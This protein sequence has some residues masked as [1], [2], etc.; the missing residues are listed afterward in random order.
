M[1][2]LS[3]CENFA[4][5]ARTAITFAAGNKI[6]GGDVGVSPGTSITGAYEI[7][8]G[9]LATVDDSKL[10][11]T[12]AYNAWDAAMV[13]RDDAKAL[14]VEMG[15]NIFEPGTWHSDNIT[16][17]AGIVFL[18][19]LYQ[20]NPVFL[21]QADISMAV[22]AGVKI[23]LINGAKAENVVW[24]LRTS[25][26]FGAN[27]DFKGSILAGT[28]IVFGADVKVHGCVVAGTA[29]TF[30]AGDSVT[31]FPVSG[32]P[33]FGAPSSPPSVSPSLI[34]TLS[35]TSFPSA[36]PT[37]SPTEIPT[38]S[39]TSSPTANPSNSPTIAPTQSSEIPTLSPTA[40]PSVTPS[41]SPTITTE[42]PTSSPSVTSLLLLIP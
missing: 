18:D 5:H 12:S 26:V 7:V 3:V 30:G 24:A 13:I 11:A 6:V 17:A 32:S 16:I 21:F 14:P 28:T 2:L 29:I 37:K 39:P 1:T 38:R 35:P 9:K 33:S 42:S 23:I 19:G 25:A 22:G 27:I 10:F 15:G 40:S 31:S 4:V 8:D 41:K 20:P 34:P 36:T